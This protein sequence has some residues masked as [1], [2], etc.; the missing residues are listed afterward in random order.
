MVMGALARRLGGCGP[1]SPAV[2]STKRLWGGPMFPLYALLIGTAS[3][4]DFVFPGSLEHLCVYPNQVVIGTVLTRDS[5]RGPSGYID[6]KVKFD[7]ERVLKGTPSDPMTLY[8]GG[9]VIGD[10]RS[11]DSWSPRMP[12]GSRYLLFLTT[13]GVPKTLISKFQRLDE[14]VSLPS[15]EELIQELNSQC[16]GVN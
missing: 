10:V 9:G 4:A 8:I 3:G 11:F 5:Y 16:A 13:E 12:P 6:S 15:N 14:S 1:S 7:V 2:V